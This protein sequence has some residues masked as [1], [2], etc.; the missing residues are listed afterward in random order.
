M[1][2]L[3]LRVWGKGHSLYVLSGQRV[4]FLMPQRPEVGVFP[5]VLLP[6]VLDYD[7]YNTR[8]VSMPFHRPT[9]L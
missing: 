6:L 3:N 5:S 8:Q 2:L 7:L 9:V 1:D 4:S